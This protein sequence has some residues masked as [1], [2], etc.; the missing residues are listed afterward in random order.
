MIA[1]D[2]P[3]WR[4]HLVTPLLEYSPSQA[5]PH[6][7]R[8]D[9]ATQRVYRF[10]RQFRNRLIT[11]LPDFVNAHEVWMNRAYQRS[12]L[13][14]L[15]IGGA[16][17]EVIQA[18]MEIGKDDIAAYVSMFF[19]VRGRRKADI[20][21]MVFK[22]MPHKGFHA[23]DTL[24]VLHRIGWFGGYRLVQVILSQGLNADAEQQFCTNVCKDIMRR[25]LPEMGM[26]AGVQAQLAP[27]FLKLASDWDADKPAVSPTT[28]LEDH[29]IKAVGE[30]VGKQ[31]VSVADPTV[32]ANL[33]LPAA[34]PCYVETY[35]VRK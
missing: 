11:T 18:E 26:G 24:G 6:V 16:T 28:E 3:D 35:E 25:Q 9:S 4:W 14:G 20:A 23:H 12:V 31:G 29:I 5:A 34:E 7:Q 8:M 32:E 33:K 1:P 2:K 19:D 27:E 10:R 21:N 15:L 13:E 17:D 22:G 30:G